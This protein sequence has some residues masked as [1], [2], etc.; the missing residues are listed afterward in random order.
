MATWKPNTKT[1]ALNFAEINAIPG[2]YGKGSDTPAVI[3][4]VTGVSVG[5]D[6]STFNDVAPVLDSSSFPTD[7]KFIRLSG[8]L[9]TDFTS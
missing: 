2:V 4:R 6:P 9:T 7:T 5:L 3:T 1:D 8:V